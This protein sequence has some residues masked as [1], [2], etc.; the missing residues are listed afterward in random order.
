MPLNGLAPVQVP[1]RVGKERVWEVGLGEQEG[2]VGTAVN[3]KELFLPKN[4]L[5]KTPSTVAEWEGR[6]TMAG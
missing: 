2:W 4:G 1:T 3:W 5:T 6:A